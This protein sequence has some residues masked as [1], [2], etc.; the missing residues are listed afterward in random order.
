MCYLRQ[1]HLHKSVHSRFAFP[2]EQ[3]VQFPLQVHL[4][5]SL[6]HLATSGIVIQCGI[7]LSPSL[8]HPNSD[9]DG[10]FGIV[11]FIIQIP[12]KGDKIKRAKQGTNF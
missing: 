6:V 8:F 7:H 10:K 5:S 9:G 3:E 2:Q 4:T 11:E 12:K 1:L